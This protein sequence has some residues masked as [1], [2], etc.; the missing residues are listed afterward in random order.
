MKRLLLDYL[1]SHFKK[2]RRARGGIW[3]KIIEEGYGM[4]GSIPR[5]T[6]KPENFQ[7]VKK[8]EY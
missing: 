5:W 3:Y 6:Q 2:Y 8:E 4:Q 7:V 1:F